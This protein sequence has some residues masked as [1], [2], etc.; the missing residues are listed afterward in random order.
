MNA[1][2]LG[3]PAKVDTGMYQSP[4]VRLS[5]YTAGLRYMIPVPYYRPI[6]ATAILRN[7]VTQNNYVPGDIVQHILTD[8]AGVGGCGM[9][10]DTNRLVIVFSSVQYSIKQALS[11]GTTVLTTP[12]SWDLAFRVIG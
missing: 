4:W 7:V 3:I 9:T 12:T 6:F 1:G 11:A 10:M 2:A 8:G 5:S